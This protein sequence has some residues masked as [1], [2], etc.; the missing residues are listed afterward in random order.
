MAG[1]ATRGRGPIVY[2]DAIRVKL[3]VAGQVQ[4]QAV[5]LGLAINPEGHKELRGL[6]AGESGGE[7]SKFWLSVLIELKDRGVQDILIAAVGGLKGFPDAID[8]VF[9]NTR[10]QLCMVHLLRG[11]TASRV[12]EGTQ[13]RGL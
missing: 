6:W 2:F 13:G 5:Y 4:N 1:S 3:P 10:V 8:A 7:G 11:L 9:P 12:L